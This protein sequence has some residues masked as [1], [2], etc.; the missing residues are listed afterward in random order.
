[1]D[2]IAGE[3]AYEAH[4]VFWYRFELLFR[5][6]KSNKGKIVYPD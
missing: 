2:E 1:L 4:G 3:N 6:E 5:I